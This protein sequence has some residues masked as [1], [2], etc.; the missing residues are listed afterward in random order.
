MKLLGWTLLTV[1]L[2]ILVLAF[3]RGG[4]LSLVGAGVAVAGAAVAFSQAGDGDRG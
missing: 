2:G 3:L 4:Q 1:G